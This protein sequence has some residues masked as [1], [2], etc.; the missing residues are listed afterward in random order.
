[1]RSIECRY[2]QWPCVTPNYTPNH[3]I[4]D[5]LFRLSYLCSDNS[6]Y[7]SSYTLPL[8]LL[9]SLPFPLTTFMHMTLSSSSLSTHLTLTQA[10]LTFKTLFN[11]P[12]FGCPLIF[13]LLNSSKT[14]LL[15]IGLKNQ[16][17]KIHNSSLDTSHFAQIFGLIFDE[18][19]TFSDQ[20]TSIS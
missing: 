5:I 1:M 4:F 14:E 10:F 17:A 7:S 16:L 15:L 8:S 13:L 9:W 6:H 3:S 11:R 18:H 2:L 19:L 12:I 20:I